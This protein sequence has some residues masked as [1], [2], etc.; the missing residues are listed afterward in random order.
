MS[1]LQ[2]KCEQ[3]FTHTDASIV[4][5]LIRLTRAAG[6]FDLA[7]IIAIQQNFA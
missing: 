6:E 7:K 4:D 2:V 1:S 5:D 3:M